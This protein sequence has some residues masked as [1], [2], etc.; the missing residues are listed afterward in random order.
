LKGLEE[1]RFPMFLHAWFAD[2]PDPDNFLFKLFYSRSSR[3]YV[4][5]AN[6]VV[7]GLLLDA[8]RPREE[9]PLHRMDL[10]RKA[11]ELILEDAA[12]LPVWHYAYERLFQP[13][14]KSIDV[15]GLGD[16]YIPLRK[17]WLDRAAR[18]GG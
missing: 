1:K 11:E 7:D 3:N 5:Y 18:R 2:V 13:Y 4:G 6:P 9:N 15:N 8:R 14:V 17:I 10:Y 16:P 12:I